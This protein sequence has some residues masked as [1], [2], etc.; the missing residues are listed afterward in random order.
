MPRKRAGQK[1]PDPD[2]MTYATG[3]TADEVSQKWEAGKL[4][5]ELG[6]REEPA[7]LWER[8]YLCKRRPAERSV[9]FEV[10]EGATSLRT[11]PIVLHRVVARGLGGHWVYTLCEECMLLLVSLTEREEDE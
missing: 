7:A 8:C 9:T 1:P 6:D 11:L 3:L 5:R 2:G 10:A 4:L